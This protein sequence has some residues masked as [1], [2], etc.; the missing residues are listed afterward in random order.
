MAAAEPPILNQG[1]SRRALMGAGALA[2]AA[3]RVALAA[4]EP[5]GFSYDGKLVQGGFLIGRSD[6]RATLIVDGKLMGRASADGLF[7]VGFDRDA[8]SRA[9]IDVQRI[10]GEA[11][12]AF[13]IRP[14]TYRVQ[15]INGLPKD[16]VAPT[17]P[18]LLE[19]IAREAALKAEAYA[20]L[21]DRDDG[22]R[23]GFVWPVKFTRISAKFGGQRILDGVPQAPHYG[24]DL[25]ASTGTPIHAPAPGLVVLA[26]PDLHYEGGLTLIDHGQGLVAGYLHQSRQFVRRGERVERGQEIGLVGMT[27]RATGP[28]LDWRAK[29]RGRNIDPSFMVGATAPTPGPD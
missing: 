9:Q 4:I 2:L 15:R 20:S 27:G 24:L 10:G 5:G 16:E 3:P 29:W 21:D 6:P 7:V 1:L 26:E 25:A 28:H 17:D 18:A 11:G 8:P 19:R 22:F 12:R 13:T 23:D 14:T